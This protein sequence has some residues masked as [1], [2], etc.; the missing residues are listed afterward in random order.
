MPIALS[1]RRAGL[2]AATAIM[3]RA[4]RASAAEPVR[5]GL[6]AALSGQSA[7]SGE[8]ITRGLTVAMDEVTPAAACWAV[9]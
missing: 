1:R 7:K 3:A 2:L 6:V 9:R 5:L 4:S 8:G